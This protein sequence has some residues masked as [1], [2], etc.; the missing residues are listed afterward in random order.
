MR[1]SVSF[2]AAPAAVPPRSVRCNGFSLVE[3]MVVLAIMGLLATAAVLT[4]PGDEA[5]LRR[6]A[7][8]FRQ[9][10]LRIQ[11]AG[12]GNRVTEQLR[13]Q[14]QAIETVLV[15]QPEIAQQQRQHSC[16]Q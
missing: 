10:V 14:A 4:I 6:E 3:M 15:P 5:K 16:G 12:D 7:E 13:N 9:T 11:Q 2:A 1:E 8:R